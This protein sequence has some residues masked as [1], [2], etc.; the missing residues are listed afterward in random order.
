[1]AKRWQ[2][3]TWTKGTGATVEPAGDADRPLPGARPGGLTSLPPKRP[4]PGAARPTPA[5]PEKQR[6]TREA[7]R[8]RALSYLDSA[9]I[10]R[11]EELEAELEG[12][13]GS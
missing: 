12:R 2:L 10:E 5:R 4:W 9:S 3:R 1:M 7:R 8:R 6:V 13:A 11:L